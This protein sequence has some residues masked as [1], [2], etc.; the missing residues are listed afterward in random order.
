[1]SRIT[2]GTPESL[3]TVNRILRSRLFS[4]TM[5]NE[6]APLASFFANTA[7][8]GAVPPRIFGSTVIFTRVVAPQW[9]LLLPRF[10]TISKPSRHRGFDPPLSLASRC[11]PPPSHCSKSLHRDILSTV[12]LSVFT[13]PSRLDRRP[14]LYY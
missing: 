9:I 14:R 8:D 12:F 6:Q 1:M 2:A 5:G 3:V 4:S 11:L 10:L 7:M 13:N